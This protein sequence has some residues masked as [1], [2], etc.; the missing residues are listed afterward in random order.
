VKKSENGGISLIR[1]RTAAL[2]A[3]KAKDKRAESIPFQDSVTQ[4]H[5]I[6]LKGPFIQEEFFVLFE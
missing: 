2:F 3:S 6:T 5:H 4:G 1:P